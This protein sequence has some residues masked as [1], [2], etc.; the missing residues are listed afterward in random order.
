MISSNWFLKWKWKKKKVFIVIPCSWRINVHVSTCAPQCVAMCRLPPPRPSHRHVDSS[1][2]TKKNSCL[3]RYSRGSA[4][5]SHG[6]MTNGT[7]KNRQEREKRTNSDSLCRP[8]RSHNVQKLKSL[9]TLRLCLKI[10]TRIT[11]LNLRSLPPATWEKHVWEE[12]RTEVVPTEGGGDS[13][14]VISWPWR[15]WLN[16]SAGWPV[17]LTPL[18]PGRR[19]DTVSYLLAWESAGDKKQK[20]FS[21]KPTDTS[22][23]EVLAARNARYKRY[24]VKR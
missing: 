20:H 3:N 16:F 22:G 2:F 9:S 13:A 8:H 23:S 17:V 6:R 19:K 12:K 21:V 7:N 5:S 4:P 24:T 18:L 10:K 15:P 11:K 14:A 1:N